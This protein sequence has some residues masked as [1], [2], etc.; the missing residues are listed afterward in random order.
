M[1]EI[2][3]MYPLFLK[4]IDDT[5]I[6]KI[7]SDEAP[8][9]DEDVDIINNV[10]CLNDF[11]RWQRTKPITG[12]DFIGTEFPLRTQTLT[13]YPVI[14]ECKPISCRESVV[15][16]RECLVLDSSVEANSLFEPCDALWDVTVFDE[17]TLIV[18][19]YL[20]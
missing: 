17:P 13:V 12:M 15:Q 5:T 8:F 6:I 20:K 2:V 16:L 7:F 9:F 3:Q 19:H 18:Y 10:K 14:D 1:I 4:V 11:R